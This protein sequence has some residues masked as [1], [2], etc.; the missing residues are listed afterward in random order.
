MG[1]WNTRYGWYRERMHDLAKLGLMSMAVGLLFS[2]GP[3]GVN[4]ALAEHE[5]NAPAET[6]CPPDADVKQFNIAAFRLNIVYNSYGD[7][8]PI[9][10]IYAFVG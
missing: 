2:F 1:I 7:A 9:G 10:S 5:P 3:S 4:V 6:A 8:D